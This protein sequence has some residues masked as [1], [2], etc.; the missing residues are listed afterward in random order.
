[1]L[2][3]NTG[4]TGQIVYT[5]AVST[6]STAQRRW[7]HNLTPAWG[8]TQLVVASGAEPKPAHWRVAVAACP[9]SRLALAGGSC[10]LVA[11]LLARPHDGLD[12]ASGDL[13]VTLLSQRSSSPAPVCH[14]FPWPH[15]DRPTYR[16]MRGF[17]FDCC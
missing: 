7:R 16:H 2:V 1:M 5:G 10:A 15:L 4:R 12:I 8:L 11:E 17:D 6:S 9:G 13:L 3:Y 14:A